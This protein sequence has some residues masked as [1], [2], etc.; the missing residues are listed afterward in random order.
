MRVQDE[1][2]IFLLMSKVMWFSA[3]EVFVVIKLMETVLLGVD[4]ALADGC[5]VWEHLHSFRENKFL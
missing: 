4:A 3:C 5:R 2:K 1:S